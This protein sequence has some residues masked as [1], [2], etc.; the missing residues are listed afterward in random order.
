MTPPPALLER[1]YRA[2]LFFLA[3]LV[4]GFYLAC[5]ASGVVRLCFYDDPSGLGLMMLGVLLYAAGRLA[6]RELRQS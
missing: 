2:L 5:M 1:L 6:V 3:A 4:L